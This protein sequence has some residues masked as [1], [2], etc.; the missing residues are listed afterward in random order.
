MEM[1]SRITKSQKHKI[2]CWRVTV[3]YGVNML[4]ADENGSSDP[5]CVLTFD[6]KQQV[7]KSKKCTV[8]PIW[9]ETFYF[10]SSDP[11]AGQNPHDDGAAIGGSGGSRFITTSNSYL[12]LQCFDHDTLSADDFLGQCSVCL[13]GVSALANFKDGTERGVSIA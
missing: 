11:Y 3:L 5:Y 12:T 6:R 1:A 7:T 4:V 8:H 2:N 9:N 13:D 10:Q